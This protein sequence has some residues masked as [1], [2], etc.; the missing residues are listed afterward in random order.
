MG[1]KHPTP[2]RLPP[3]V[4]EYDENDPSCKSECLW[5]RAC[6]DRKLQRGITAPLR[7]DQYPRKVE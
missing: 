3:C 6:K 1:K 7:D 2:D 5:T 4:G